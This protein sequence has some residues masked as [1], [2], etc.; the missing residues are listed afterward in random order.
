MR[1]FALV[2][3][4]VAP[5]RVVIGALVVA[6]SVLAFAP[7]RL[8]IGCGLGW[9]L[10]ALSL[11]DWQDGILPDLLTLPLAAAGL[12]ASGLDFQESLL[13]VLAGAGLLALPALAYRVLR[14]RDGLGWGDVKLAAAA[15]AWLGW[16]AIPTMILAAAML[17][18]GA[19]LMRR[20]WVKTV[21]DET[22]PFGPALAVTTWVLW[23]TQ[24]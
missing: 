17:G 15:G 11:I 12:V 22:I 5:L 16:Q 20:W 7:E 13:G 23:L 4:P 9:T 19:V 3:T 14:H 1:S 18:I 21:F 2:S 10:L 6:V 24:S 8:W